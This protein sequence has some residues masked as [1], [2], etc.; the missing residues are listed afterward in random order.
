MITP[1]LEKLILQQK[2]KYYRITIGD[3]PLSVIQVP[4]GHTCVITDLEVFANMQ[5]PANNP[6]TGSPL[7]SDFIGFIVKQINNLGVSDDLVT[8]WV[9]QNQWYLKAMITQLIEDSQDA[10][11]VYTINCKQKTEYNIFPYADQSSNMGTFQFPSFISEKSTYNVFNIHRHNITFRWA[12]PFQIDKNSY[13]N[14]VTNYIKTGLLVY[15]GATP[16]MNKQLYEKNAPLGFK[17]DGLR[18]TGA[19]VYNDAQLGLWI[20]SGKIA[21]NREWLLAQYPD[22]FNYIQYPLIANQGAANA[23]SGAHTVDYNLNDSASPEVG[24]FDCIFTYLMR[25]RCNVG[26][27]II[28]ENTSF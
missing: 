6:A 23:N 25:P 10:T 1:I 15:N 14:I 12:Y 13:Q 24:L 4:T 2:A 9:T 20:P 5:I 17:Q 19:I 18:A 27:V 28:N 16:V 3:S 22:Q 21:V 11:N 7:I 26:Y 8:N